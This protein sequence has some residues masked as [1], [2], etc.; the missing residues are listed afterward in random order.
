M[1]AL[2]WTDVMLSYYCILAVVISSIFV[3]SSTSSSKW[4]LPIGD[5]MTPEEQ[6]EAA[7]AACSS[8]Q[9][10]RLTNDVALFDQQFDERSKL[11]ASQGRSLTH[12]MFATFGARG[13]FNPVSVILF[14]LSALPLH[15]TLIIHY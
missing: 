6:Y 10:D 2:R 4:S 15:N 1:V 14:M 9:Y 12:V 8:L 5:D 3:V 11:A 13:H 7:A